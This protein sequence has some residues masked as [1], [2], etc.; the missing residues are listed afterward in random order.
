MRFH[1]MLVVRH[2]E[3]RGEAV[4]RGRRAVQVCGFH[5]ERQRVAGREALLVRIQLELQALGQE[6]LDAEDEAVRA[7][8]LARVGG[9]VDRPFAGGRID[10]DLAR[11]LVVAE[12]ARAHLLLHHHPAVGLA[13]RGEQR[14]RRGQRLAV[15]VAQ[16]RGHVDRLARAEQVAARPREDFRRALRAAGD[17][18]FG[19]VERRLVERQ[20]GNVAAPRRDQHVLGLRVV[21]ERREPFAVARRGNDGVAL[22]VAHRDL[23]AA[24][25]LARLERGRVHD[26]LVLVR[27]H[28]QADVA[29]E[30]HRRVE[31]GVELARAAHHREVQARRLQLGDVAHRQVGQRALVRR[32]VDREAVLVDGVGERGELVQRPVAA[33]AVARVAG[34]ELRQVLV[35]HAQ[36][37]DV[38]VRHVHGD[39]RQAARLVRRQHAALAREAE[40]RLE[41]AGVDDL[42]HVG[43]DRLAAGRGE[44]RLDRHRVLLV[45]LEVREAQALVVVVQHPGTVDLLAVRAGDRRE[46]VELLRA[47]ERLGERHDRRGAA[48]VRF[49]RRA[50]DREAGRRRGGR[51]RRRGGGRSVV[52]ASAATGKQD[53]RD[54]RRQSEARK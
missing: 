10:R 27:A 7:V 30:E 6:F 8:A 34:E 28:V 19:K 42:L 16:Q 41:R 32:G 52:A 18:E 44:R 31:L 21:R 11:E 37:L 14:L 20:H 36:E 3:L 1:R 49:G 48:V 53:E 23:D 51:G 35:A 47:G 38:D 9:E 33:A 25:R 17:R 15:V 13:Q 26:E 50:R 4:A 5:G 39:D 24:L 29:H 2:R 22:R 54:Q 43:A 46:L 12:L 45:R 40:Q